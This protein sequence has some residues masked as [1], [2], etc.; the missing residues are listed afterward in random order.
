MNFAEDTERTMTRNGGSVGSGLL[1][2]RERYPQAMVLKEF[3]PLLF[4]IRRM[5]VLRGDDGRSEMRIELKLYLLRG[6]FLLRPLVSFTQV[7][8]VS[9]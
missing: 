8:N 2:Q 6:K 9:T 3:V 4:S 7:P 1:L 5:T